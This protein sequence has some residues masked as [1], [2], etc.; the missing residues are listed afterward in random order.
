[1]ADDKEN[2]VLEE[3]TV[4]EETDSTQITGDFEYNYSRIENISGIEIPEDG[5][6]ADCKSVI[7]LAA[8]AFNMSNKQTAYN[9]AAF[10]KYM[11]AI[12]SIVGKYNDRISK[13]EDHLSNHDDKIKELQELVGNLDLEDTTS[14]IEATKKL[15]KALFDDDNYQDDFETGD[16]GI[17]ADHRDRIVS[18]EN[19]EKVTYQY[20]GDG[21]NKTHRVALKHTKE[22]SNLAN[23]DVTLNQ[24]EIYT[25]DAVD[26]IIDNAFETRLTQESSSVG[27]ETDSDKFIKG[28]VET[29]AISP[30]TTDN[31]STLAAENENFLMSEGAIVETFNE[32]IAILEAREATLK[33]MAE[34]YGKFLATFQLE[35]AETDDGVLYCSRRI[36]DDKKSWKANAPYGGSLVVDTENAIT[37]GTKTYDLVKYT[38]TPENGVLTIEM[39]A[40]VPRGT[41]LTTQEREYDLIPL[42]VF[43][44]GS[45]NYTLLTAENGPWK[46]KNIV[47]YCPD[48]KQSYITNGTTE[49]AIFAAQGEQGIQGFQGVSIKDITAANAVSTESGATNTYKITLQ[50]P[51]NGN[52]ETEKTFQVTNGFGFRY[53]G[54]LTSDKVDSL[55]ASGVYTTAITEANWNDAPSGKSVQINDYVILTDDTGCSIRVFNGTSWQEMIKGVKGDTGYT[56]ASLSF[57]ATKDSET[58]VTTVTVTTTPHDGT[59]ASSETFTINDGEK[60]ETGATGATGATGR[61]ISAIAVDDSYTPP[62]D[63]PNDIQI[64]VEYTDGNRETF[65]V[66][67]GTNGSNGENGAGI[68]WL[69]E[70][71]SHN[72]AN[73]TPNALDAYHNTITGCSYIYTGSEWQV[74]T[75]VESDYDIP[76]YFDMGDY[77]MEVG[78]VTKNAWNYDVT[79]TVDYSLSNGLVAKFKAVTGNTTCVYRFTHSKVVAK[80]LCYVEQ[81]SP[82]CQQER[83]GELPHTRGIIFMSQTEWSKYTNVDDTDSI[84]AAAAS[85]GVTSNYSDSSTTTGD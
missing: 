16:G 68:N 58:G 47:Y 3:N 19:E 67:G 60:G 36:G 18:L 35:E 80:G 6:M 49:P 31:H 62:D 81:C 71:S 69:G 45:K 52:A 17:I 28:Q 41:R 66:K 57:S 30:T 55:P 79:G 29:T 27:T 21:D 23:E 84:I 72:K 24:T 63:K 13:N 14:L 48:K 2:E 1:M 32:V 44:G 7:E 59:A 74:L 46:S 65:I 75:G 26:A 77:F 25:A 51:A 56:G 15:V 42:Q 10:Q 4:A 34:N 37:V 78:K 33:G 43:F 8:M 76:V 38:Y 82:G 83:T 50:D 53:I 64:V 9:K 85:N 61:G 22:G 11:S 70:F 73:A 39:S 40:Y 5:S 54:T 20:S 12:N